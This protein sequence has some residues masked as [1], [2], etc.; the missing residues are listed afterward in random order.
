MRARP[1]CLLHGD[2][3]C[4]HSR[5]G[6]AEALADLRDGLEHA[7]SEALVLLREDA[8]DDEV[9]DCEE[10]VDAAGAYEHSGKCKGPVA[11]G[12]RGE[13]H[14]QRSRKADE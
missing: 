14:Q 12:R 5:D 11:A 1:L 4:N 9:A 2:R 3:I 10:R 6:E 13:D 7:A 8:G